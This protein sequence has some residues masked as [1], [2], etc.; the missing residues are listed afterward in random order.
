MEESAMLIDS[1]MG[2]STQHS[3]S[4]KGVTLPD[5]T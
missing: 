1:E 4:S 5:G 3:K 2:H